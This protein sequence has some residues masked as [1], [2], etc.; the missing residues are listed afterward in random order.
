VLQLA[1]YATP[2]IYDRHNPAIPEFAARL[3]GLNP[4]THFIEGA[5][6]CLM[7]GELEVGMFVRMAL[8]ASLSLAVG[9]LIYKRAKRRIIFNI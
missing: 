1:F 8:A 3:L 5:R 2:I 7:G 6:A 4:F 9:L